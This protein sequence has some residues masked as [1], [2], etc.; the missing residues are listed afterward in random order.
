MPMGIDSFSFDLF[1]LAERRTPAE[2]ETQVRRKASAET[3]GDS[4]DKQ[5]ERARDQE[6]FFWGLFPVLW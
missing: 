1:R 3:D 2:R 5:G 6:D 4:G